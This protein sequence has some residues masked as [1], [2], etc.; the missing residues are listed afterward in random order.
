MYNKI[1]LVGN[2]TREGETKFLPNAAEIYK[3]AIATTHK[4][5]KQ[6]GTMQ[7]EVCFLD[8]NCFGGQA[9]VCAKYLRKGSKVLL[10]GRLVFEQWDAQDGTKRSKHALRVETMKMLDS[11]DSSNGQANQAPQQ[12]QYN[13]NPPVQYERQNTV[14]DIDVDSDSIPF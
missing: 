3:N 11:K 12:G 7:E 5:K 9:S 6:D 13:P 14:P 8:F 2:L 10:E 1:I 4:Y